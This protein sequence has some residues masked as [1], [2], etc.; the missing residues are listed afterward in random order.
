[1]RS[2]FVALASCVLAACSIDPP[3]AATVRARVAA[4]LGN[5]LRQTRAAYDGSTAGIPGAAGVP[6]GPSG[7]PDG[8]VAWLNSNVFSDGNALGGG[9]FA[10]PASALCAAGDTACAGRVATA[11]LQVRVEQDD[12]HSL[13]FAIEIGPD[14]AQPVSLVLAHDRAAIA[15]DLDGQSAAVAALAELAGWAS[16]IA[17]TQGAIDGELAVRGDR[18]VAGHVTVSRP[19]AIAVAPA[20]DAMSGPTALRF[21]TVA[22]PVWAFEL[23][24]G[25]PLV[26]LDLG[27]GETLLH[28]PGDPASGVKS[29]DVDLAG[30]TAHLGFAGG[31][32]LAIGGISLGGKTTTIGKDGV[33]GETIDVNPSDGRALDATWVFEPAVGIDTVVVAPRLEVARTVDHG[34]LGDAPPAFDIT[35]IA[36]TG[37]LSRIQASGQLRV[38]AG[39]LAV[40]TAPAQYSFSADAG[41]CVSAASGGY[42]LA[43]CK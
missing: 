37:A 29:T 31:S 25:A 27:L 20:G 9:V 10:V 6:L 32:S 40:T 22:A 15:I 11:Q 30:A 28:V 23:D 14:H 1:M 17:N 33:V 7:D 26:Q 21:A 41:Q 35:R 13:R 3:S 16:P 42:A 19:V 36:L 18:H 2:L 34:V 38:E 4:D 43:A 24:A 5:V 39:R 12:D 8:T